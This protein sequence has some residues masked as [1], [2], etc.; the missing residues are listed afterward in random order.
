MI[1]ASRPQRRARGLDESFGDDH[2]T[3]L[4]LRYFQKPACDVDRIA[5]G[6]D[7]LL[8]RRPEA[9]HHRRAEMQADPEVQAI[10]SYWRQIGQPSGN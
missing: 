3:M 2:A 4:L 9:R 1:D 10:P 5:R 7:L 8:G 6:G